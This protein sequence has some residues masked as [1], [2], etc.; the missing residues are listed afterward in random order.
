MG[1]KV[2][3]EG[4]REINKFYSYISYIWR[5]K[6]EINKFYMYRGYKYGE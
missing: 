6:R 3:F 1:I 5:I 2:T 4:A